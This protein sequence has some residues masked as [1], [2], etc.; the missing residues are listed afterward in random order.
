MRRH[1]LAL[2]LLAACLARAGAAELAKGEVLSVVELRFMG[3][4]F[5]PKDAPARDIEL[6]VLF[7]H[8]SGEPSYTVHGFWDGD[9]KGGAAGEVFKVRFCPT[10]P[11]KWVLA[12][13]RANVPKLRGQH[14]G[15]WVTAVASKRPGFWLPDPETPG[16]RWYRRSDGS[17]PYI[18]GNTHYTFLSGRTDRGPNGSTIEADVRANARDFKKLRF[19]LFGGRYV[20]PTEKPFLDD[21]GRPT[22]DGNF[23]HRP[24]PAWFHQRADVAV[25]AAFATDL[26]ADLILN[27]PDTLESRSVLKAAKNNGDNTPF[28]RY[29]AARYGS[30]PNVWIC[31]ANE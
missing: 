9:G 6:S 31:L 27:G 29:V 8:E 11:G 21:A 20:H 17:H 12:E 5:G 28:L 14:Q 22:D 19:S 25:R 3:P 30:Y 7:R 15:G 16:S 24:N 23:S 26:I 2:L 18:F 4:T 13:V 1:A 10:K